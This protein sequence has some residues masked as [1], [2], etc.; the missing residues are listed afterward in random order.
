MYK[1]ENLYNH[2]SMGH[3]DFMDGFLNQAYAW[4]SKI[5]FVWTSVCVRVHTCVYVHV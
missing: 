3:A 5:P 4:F 1:K 2:T